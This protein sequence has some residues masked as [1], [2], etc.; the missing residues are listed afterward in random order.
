MAEEGEKRRKG[1]G[2][3]GRFQKSLELIILLFLSR[4]HKTWEGVAQQR[5]VSCGETDD[6]L[7]SFGGVLI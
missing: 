7:L 2:K 5:S 4:N 1:S 6:L 3:A